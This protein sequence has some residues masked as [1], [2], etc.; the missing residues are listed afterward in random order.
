[1]ISPVQ[2]ATSPMSEHITLDRLDVPGAMSRLEEIVAAY[3]EVYADAGDAYF[4]EERFRLQLAGHMGAPA[5]EL[6]CADLDGELVGF[7]YGFTLPAGT[8]WWR[9]LLT[10][11][12]DGF[13][14]ED[15]HR[16]LA[17]C[18]IVVRS[19]WR[20]QHVGRH[21]LDTL[22]SGRQEERATLLVD[23]DNWAAQVACAA[24]GCDGVAQ[25]RPERNGAPV[26]DVLMLDRDR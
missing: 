8:D 20:R 17:I 13:T 5:W 7:A 14:R 10:R 18:E 3:I 22:L 15:G 11:V 19:P 26:Y 23:P 16:T 24:W 25:L 9:G 6:V 21:L 4:G 1:V 2:Y 12:P